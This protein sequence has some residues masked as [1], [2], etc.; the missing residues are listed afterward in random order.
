MGKPFLCPIDVIIQTFDTTAIYLTVALAD[1]VDYSC[2]P[3][4]CSS[5]STA[6]HAKDN[7]SSL[8]AFKKDDAWWPTGCCTKAVSTDVKTNLEIFIMFTAD[9]AY[10]TREYCVEASGL[11]K[12]QN[13]HL[14]RNLLSTHGQ[15]VD[16]NECQNS[17][18]AFETI[19]L[20]GLDNCVRHEDD[21][22]LISRLAT[23]KATLI[24]FLKCTQVSERV[25]A[26]I[27][28]TA[29]VSAMLVP[30][31]WCVCEATKQ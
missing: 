3:I 25:Y 18:D 17:T 19:T 22:E 2:R 14:S 20:L 26:Q 29:S 28:T 12:G 16:S 6:V 5:I 8:I 11:T 9:I 1:H 10:W 31:C 13:S 27:L 4:A 23:N 7:L 21:S 30:E 15:K 24:I